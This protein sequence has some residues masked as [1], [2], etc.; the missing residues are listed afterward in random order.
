MNKA[1]A[2]PNRAG[3][4]I[5]NRPVY[6]TPDSGCHTVLLTLAQP[7]GSRVNV[8]SIEAEELAGSVDEEA[9]RDA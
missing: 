8:L 1:I 4:V 9:A 5:R 3:K 6:S 7:S 2:P